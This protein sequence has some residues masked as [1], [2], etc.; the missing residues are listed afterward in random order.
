MKIID[1]DQWNRRTQYYNFIQYTNPVFSVCSNIDV[2]YLVKFCKEKNQSFFSAFLYVVT[3][4]VNDVEEM[5]LRIMDDKIVL[6]DVVH[7]GYVVICEDD[8]LRTCVTSADNDYLTFYSATRK[9]LERTKLYKP[10]AYNER[11]DNDVYYVSCLPW[12]KFNSVMNPYNFSDK[13][14]TSIPRVTWGK[15]YMNA[16]RF[17]INIDISAH[18]ALVDGTHIAKVI[19]N[20]EETISTMSFIGGRGNEG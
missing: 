7:P 14:Q 5:R 12:I 4:C 3:K 17:E 9:D 1:V 20:I 13:E 16:D 2:T 8:E 19:K 15:Y 18:H 11:N 6:Y 10:E